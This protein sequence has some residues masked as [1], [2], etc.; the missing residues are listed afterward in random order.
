MTSKLLWAAA[1][2]L[3]S[4]VSAWAVDRMRVDQDLHNRVTAL[5]SQY[6][7][8]DAKLDLLLN[9]IDPN[10]SSRPRPR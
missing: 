7:A 6:S 8:I 1:A 3:L 10:A 5:E 2:I 9:Y 4:L